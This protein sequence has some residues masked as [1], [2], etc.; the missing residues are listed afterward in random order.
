M[1]CCC[2]LRILLSLSVTWM[3][4]ICHTGYRWCAR[5][6]SP[7]IVA[8]GISEL[9]WVGLFLTHLTT[10]YLVGHLSWGPH[11][12]KSFVVVVWTHYQDHRLT[13]WTSTVWV[14]G[15]RK[16]GGGG[17]STRCWTP[18]KV[19]IDLGGKRSNKDDSPHCLL[20]SS[21]SGSVPRMSIRWRRQ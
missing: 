2:M 21:A 10:S 4:G 12:R 6:W 18:P 8:S 16:F 7:Q 11:L 19:A 15:E 9:F 17:V 5:G 3:W 20:C 13:F 1:R 14:E